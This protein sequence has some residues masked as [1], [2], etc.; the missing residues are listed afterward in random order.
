VAAPPL[1]IRQADGVDLE[2]VTEI[3][4]LSWAD[5]YGA[6]LRPETLAPFLDHDRQLDYMRDVA[7]RP[8]TL[9]LVADERTRGVVG[10]ALTYLDEEPEPWLESLHVLRE[11]RSHGVG[12][13]LMRATALE[14]RAR[15]Y[16][17]MRL[18][19]VSGNQAATRF[20]ERLGATFAGREPASWAEGVWHELYRWDHLETLTLQNR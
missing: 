11:M 15:G 19:V 7:R 16:N 3:K 14:L 20:Y 5:T 6:L 1:L 12:T 10:F 9:L 18:G 4:V 2:R 13:E 8:A 17:T